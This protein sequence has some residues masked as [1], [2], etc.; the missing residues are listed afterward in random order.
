[1]MPAPKKKKP[2][3]K[4]AA[5][6]KPAEPIRDH[7]DVVTAPAGTS[8]DQV[9]DKLTGADQV[10]SLDE[11]SQAK[12]PPFDPHAG[13]EMAPGREF[14]GDPEPMLTT[15]VFMGI[16]RGGDFEDNV[17]QLVTEAEKLGLLYVTATLSH[18]DLDRHVD[19]IGAIAEELPEVDDDDEDEPDEE[20][21][22]E[23]HF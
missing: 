9:I 2:A 12:A 14:G 22:D 23:E 19:N 6:K 8:Q 1:M 7:G 3:A 17:N 20:R 13:R 4:R 5:K 15:L 18:L 16:D 21:L 10:P 11:L